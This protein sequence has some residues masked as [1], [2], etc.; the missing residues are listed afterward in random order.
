MP[1]FGRKP[2]NPCNPGP[3]RKTV[4]ILRGDQ[5]TLAFTIARIRNA[6]PRTMDA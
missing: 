1:S 4:R 2:R 3:I 5:E 6:A